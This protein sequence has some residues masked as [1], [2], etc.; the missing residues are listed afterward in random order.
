MKIFAISID[1]Q[2]VPIITMFPAGDVRNDLARGERMSFRSAD[3]DVLPAP[4]S[5]FQFLPPHDGRTFVCL[6]VHRHGVPEDHE[7][8]VV[9]QAHR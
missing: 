9:Y 8:I 1:L 7:A 5:L 6:A 2:E 3:V 4:S